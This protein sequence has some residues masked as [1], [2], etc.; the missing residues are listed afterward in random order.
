MPM[1][2]LLCDLNAS[3]LDRAPRSV[4]ETG[5]SSENT[6]SSDCRVVK[7]RT[8]TL[9]GRPRAPRSVAETG[10][11]S[12]NR[13]VA[14][15]GQRGGLLVA[16]ETMPEPQPTGPT[17][18]SSADRSQ[19]CAWTLPNLFDDACVPV[20]PDTRET[21][22]PPL[23]SDHLS[24]EDTSL[25]TWIDTAMQLAPDF[26]GD[27][28]SVFALLI[29]SPLSNSKFLPIHQVPPNLSNHGWFLQGWAGDGLEEHHWDDEADDDNDILDLPH[30]YKVQEAAEVQQDPPESQPSESEALL[31]Q[32]QNLTLG[33]EPLPS[34]ADV[35]T[36]LHDILFIKHLGI[37]PPANWHDP[38]DPHHKQDLGQIF[39]PL[40]SDF[41]QLLIEAQSTHFLKAV[42]LMDSVDP[43]YLG[44]ITGKANAPFTKID[45]SILREYHR[46]EG[47]LLLTIQH[48]A[49][50]DS[51][52][53]A[54]PMAFT[55]EQEVA[56]SALNVALNQAEA[57]S[58]P[59][60]QHTVDR[61]LSQLLKSLYFP[62][63]TGSFE[64][65]VIAFICIQSI[66]KDNG[67]WVS[68]NRI[69]KVLS[70]L[71]FAIRLRAVEEIASGS[72]DR[73]MLMGEHS[74]HAEVCRML[75]HSVRASQKQKPHALLRR[76]LELS[77]KEHW[78]TPDMWRQFLHKL[79]GCL[80]DLITTK[81]LLGIAQEDL[82]VEDALIGI[83]DRG[84][85]EVGWGPISPDPELAYS[86]GSEKL[87]EAFLRTQSMGLELS[88]L[89][90]FRVN[91]QAFESWLVD[92]QKSI[93]LFYVLAHIVGAP[94]PLAAVQESFLLITSTDKSRHPR[95]RDTFVTQGCISF[96]C[97][98]VG[99]NPGERRP[100]ADRL[101]LLPPKISQ[102][103]YL[104]V[105]VVRP[106]EMIL[107]LHNQRVL[108]VRMEARLEAIRHARDHIFSW[109]GKIMDADKRR[110]AFMKVTQDHLGIQISVAEYRRIAMAWAPPKLRG[111]AL[112]PIETT[113][114]D[115]QAGRNVATS[116]QN[117][118]VLGSNH[119]MHPRLR[120]QQLKEIRQWHDFLGFG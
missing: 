70:Y 32:L 80:E 108:P 106:V 48:Y 41:H 87:L 40:P 94:I 33:S 9:P 84:S 99:S 1:P 98:G 112:R 93:Q 85:M 19:G 23:H 60:S 111:E 77:V 92:I 55:V 54:P 47:R 110:A 82:G 24:H 69:C 6:G 66:K 29:D 113:I 90:R 52:S 50:R 12:E 49:T 83:D 102:Q 20:L 89:N 72:K 26:F 118:G 96:I 30:D 107:L 14:A 71:R 64:R 34:R 46:E 5:Q 109:G 25:E 42:G 78:L 39:R 119:G 22:S 43:S 117:Y 44:L 88:P 11:S 8:G 51:R 75:H 95:Y 81:V 62:Q 67:G 103:V 28:S 97:R 74:V 65:P 3:S 68:P 56:L 100:W 31:R 63:H 36:N 18:S 58:L 79:V 114:A 104:L 21:P 115:K 10:Q 37:P 15:R 61:A 16:M 86:P 53:R 76:G 91:Q 17:A 27:S 38:S 120:Q 2:P 73:E 35:F 116:E 59:D 4:A 13:C 45:A 105:N 57:V 101:Q 7:T